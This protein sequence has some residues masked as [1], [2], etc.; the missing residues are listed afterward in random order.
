MALTDGA[1]SSCWETEGP[2]G[3]ILLPRSRGLSPAASTS[4]DANE[5]G[6]CI[7]MMV[8]GSQQKMQ[9]ISTCGLNVLVVGR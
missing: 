1:A 2:N 8:L 3:K 5:L 7:V 9:C 6:L 4:D